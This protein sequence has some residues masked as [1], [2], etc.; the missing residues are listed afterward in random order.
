VRRW[1]GCRIELGD[2]AAVDLDPV[3][4]QLHQI[5]KGGHPGAEVV[6]RHGAAGLRNW[7]NWPQMRSK[8]V[9]AAVS[10]S[11]SSMR[12]GGMPAAAQRASSAVTSSFS[13][14]RSD[15]DAQ[16]QVFAP[17]LREGGERGEGLVDDGLADFVDECR[18]FGD[19]NEL[20]RRYE[21]T[22]V[23]PAQQHFA[24]DHPAGSDRSA[25]G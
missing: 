6:D 19:G 18:L 20:G 5:G 11:S 13:N 14:S 22:G 3:V 12:D 17:G 7:F 2:E 24:A 4:G 21:F 16:R 9:I 25:A 1:L 15:V 10:S 23:V 8:W